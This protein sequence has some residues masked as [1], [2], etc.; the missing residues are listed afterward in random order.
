MSWTTYKL[1]TANEYHQYYYSNPLIYERQK[2]TALENHHKKKNEKKITK[3][4]GY[5]NILECFNRR[6]TCPPEP[7]DN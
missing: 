2:K 4:E 5:K 1:Q 6:G 7:P 3:K